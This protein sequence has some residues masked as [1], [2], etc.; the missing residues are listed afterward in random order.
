MLAL[1][2]CITVFEASTSASGEFVLQTP[3]RGFAPGP[4]WG[5]L[6][7]IALSHILNTPLSTIVVCTALDILQSGRIRDLAKGDYGERVERA[8]S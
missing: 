8:K 1:Y 4:H 6:G 3:Y 5:T 2:V 7:S